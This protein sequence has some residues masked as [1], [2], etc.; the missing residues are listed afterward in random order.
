VV[1]VRER[2]RKDREKIVRAQVHKIIRLCVLLFV[3][4]ITTSSV[5]RI[6]EKN[7]AIVLHVELCFISRRDWR[8]GAR[9]VEVCEDQ[10]PSQM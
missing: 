10:S 4:A 6:E 1:F 2:E 5:E 7:I 9:R 3:R 8:D